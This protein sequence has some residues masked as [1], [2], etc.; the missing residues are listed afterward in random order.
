MENV[1]WTLIDADRRLSAQ[2]LGVVDA[3][4]VRPVFSDGAPRVSLIR[5]LREAAPSVPC[6]GVV[7]VP[8]DIRH[9]RARL[10]PLL[11]AGLQD[12]FLIGIDELD[13]LRRSILVAQEVFAPLPTHA[14]Q[15]IEEVE[16]LLDLS[17]GSLPSRS[18]LRR[19]PKQLAATAGISLRTLSNRFRGAG[20][21]SPGKALRH[22]RL[23]LAAELLSR[24]GARLDEI[25][26]TV[27]YSSSFSL[28]RALRRDAR[29]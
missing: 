5:A 28:R 24:P 18:T 7:E 14:R 8:K 13:E 15:Q 9:S 1:I 3:I 20:L 10:P 12:I 2:E 16:R 4:L 22:M 23:E 21:D 6:I 17:A 11:R 29:S 26:V 19:S 25:A 27:G